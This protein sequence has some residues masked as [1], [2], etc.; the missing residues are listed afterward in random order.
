MKFVFQFLI[1]ALF[2]ATYTVFLYYSPIVEI[3]VITPDTTYY[4]CIDVN[5]FSNRV[6]QRYLGRLLHEIVKDY[7]QPGTAGF[8]YLYHRDDDPDDVYKIGRTK[9]TV[10]V[11]KRLKQW[12]S[13]CN[14]RLKLIKKWYCHDHERAE[15][16][17]HLELKLNGFW[18]GKR[19][20]GCKDTHNEFFRANIDTLIDCCDFW[21]DFLNNR[22]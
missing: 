8:I 2:I 15:A 19:Q 17:I 14:K 11:K 10:G 16:V 7:N 3:N 20:C 4:D 5:L 13:K 1:V 6:K 21:T 18:Y 22:E 9:A 12:S